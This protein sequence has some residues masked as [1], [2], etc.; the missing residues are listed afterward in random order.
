VIDLAICK[1]CGKEMLDHVSCD[2]IPFI[3]AETKEKYD[4]IPYN[5]ECGKYCHDCGAP[6]GGYHHVGCDMERCPMCGLQLISC[7]CDFE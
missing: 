5:G 6:I 2:R 3:D 1:Y 4:P 7:G